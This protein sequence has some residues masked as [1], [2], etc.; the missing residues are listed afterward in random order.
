LVPAFAFVDTEL[1]R[2]SRRRNCGLISMKP[3]RLA[4]L[5][6][7]TDGQL[8][9]RV[10]IKPQS[11]GGYVVGGTDPERPEMEILAYV[12][13]GSSVVNASGAT[14]GDVNAR[15][16]FSAD[17]A[18]IQTSSL[19]YAVEEGDLV[20]LLDMDGA[21]TLRVSRTAAFGTDRTLLFLVGTAR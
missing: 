1:L 2:L 17:T 13:R 9:Q 19:P 10:L 15:M 12:A 8:G 4:I 5:H 21:P 3:S 16:R 20:Q 11:T 7:A 14:P 18:K 6:A